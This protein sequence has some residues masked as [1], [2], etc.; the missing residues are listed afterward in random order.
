MHKQL[1]N[2]LIHSQMQSHNT[3]VQQLGNKELSSISI[4]MHNM[5]LEL[6]VRTIVEHEEQHK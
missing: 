5:S 2:K 3:L 1:N 4:L 6:E